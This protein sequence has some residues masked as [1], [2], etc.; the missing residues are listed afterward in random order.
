[1][2][3]DTVVHRIVRPPVRLL[4]RTRVAPD[5]LTALRFITALMAAAAFAS[6][7][8]GWV[9]VGAGLFL[10]SALLDRADGELARQTGR[11]S[12]RGRRYDLWADCSAGMMA[13]AGLGL[14]A[15]HGA[16]GLAAPVLGL[17]AA[18]GVSVL[19]WQDNS[20]RSDQLPR[21]TAAGGRVLADPD[22]A[23]LAVPPLLWCFGPD[24][25]L[26]LAGTIT[27][28]VVL[29]MTWKASRA[30]RKVSGT[31]RAGSEVGQP[32]SIPPLT[33]PVREANIPPRS[34]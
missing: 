5:H 21:Y 16:L 27:P 33:R 3:H 17:L 10:L 20:D 34:L 28:A 31:E 26:L 4:A 14:G 11:F 30:A 2:S 22:D 12:Q 1:M 8:R 9:D 15:A 24:T 7:R 25:V 23:M 32:G 6:P 13:F 19:F 29:W 18:F